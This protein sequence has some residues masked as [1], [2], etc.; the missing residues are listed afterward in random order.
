MLISTK[1]RYALSVMIDIARHKEEGFIPLRDIAKRQELSQKYLEAIFK[2][3]GEKGFVEGMRGKNGGYRLSK[4]PDQISVL[5][6]IE[7]AEGGIEPVT[8]L[9]REKDKRPQEEEIMWL[10]EGLHDEI[11]RYLDSLSLLS[12]ADGVYKERDVA[13]IAN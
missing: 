1:G 12:L 7:T 2:P 6:I 4:S 13:P 5:D 9:T 11:Q 3:L 8:P 10:W